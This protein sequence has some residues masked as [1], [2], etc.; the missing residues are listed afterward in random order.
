MGVNNNIIA[1][2]KGNEATF[3]KAFLTKLMVEIEKSSLL[4]SGLMVGYIAERATFYSHPQLISL[5]QEYKILL[6]KIISGPDEELKLFAA[7]GLLLG[8]HQEISELIPIVIEGL[9]H[10]E[11]IIRDISYISLKEHLPP[12]LC[13]NSLDHFQ[14]RA[15]AIGAIQEWWNSKQAM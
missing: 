7:S 9:N 12:R 10:Q 2:I 14:D 8:N 4:E 3:S 15:E 5:G 6:E 1:L 11:F 13:Y